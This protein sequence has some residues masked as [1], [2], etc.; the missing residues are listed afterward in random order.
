MLLHARCASASAAAIPFSRPLSGTEWRLLALLWNQLWSE[1]CPVHSP[2]PAVCVPSAQRRMPSGM[3]FSKGYIFEGGVRNL[4]AV[5]GPGIE[6][7]VIDSTMVDASDVLPTI[8]ALAG[9]DPGTAGARA[10]DGISF[11]PQ[12]HPTTAAPAALTARRGTSLST[13]QQ[14]NRRLVLLG[15][16]CWDANAIPDLDSNRCAAE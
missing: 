16:H 6:G 9:I 14:L 8:A 2:C 15:P 5:R 13:P 3:A 10:W 4:L 12:L 1:A 7:G 11:T